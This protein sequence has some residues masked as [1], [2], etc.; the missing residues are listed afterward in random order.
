MRAHGG[1]NRRQAT[2]NRRWSVLGD[3]LRPEVRSTPMSSRA[4]ALVIT[5]AACALAATAQAG[6]I[7]KTLDVA[8]G[9]SLKPDA[10]TPVGCIQSLTVGTTSLSADIETKFPLAPASSAKCVAVMSS[11]AWSTVATDPVSLAGRV[12]PDNQAKLAAL[13][14]GSQEVTFQLAIYEYDPVAKRYFASVSSGGVDLKGAA[15]A[16]QI[17]VGA[18]P[19]TDPSTPKSQDLS[20]TLKP[21]GGAQKINLSTSPGK[22]LGKAWGTLAL[23]S[24]ARRGSASPWSEWP[25]AAWSR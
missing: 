11:F 4:R 18:T 2:G 16:G 20:L 12:T 15:D 24:R 21:R 3:V 1:R 8:Q 5:A 7:Q 13:G 9:F 22:F 10:T 17:T 25:A 6:S 23:T 14:A 19:A